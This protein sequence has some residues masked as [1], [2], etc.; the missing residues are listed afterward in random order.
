MYLNE[1]DATLKI[2]QGKWK[3]VILYELYESKVVRFNA[4]REIIGEISNKT[5]THQLRELES[6]GL[7]IRTVHPTIPPHVDY[8]LSEKGKT[9]IPVLNMICDWGLENTDHDQLETTLC[10]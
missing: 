2:I 9:I 8:E 5:L 6:D 4:M 7:V 1:F 10:R 3:T